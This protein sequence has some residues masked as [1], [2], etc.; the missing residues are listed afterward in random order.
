MVGNESHSQRTLNSLRPE[1]TK[2]MLWS[3][4]ETVCDAE[5]EQTNQGEWMKAVRLDAR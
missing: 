1:D 5:L 3:C 2:R 4:N